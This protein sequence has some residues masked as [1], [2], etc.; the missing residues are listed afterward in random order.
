MKSSQYQYKTGINF[1]KKVAIA[2]P[3]GIKISSYQTNTGID[4]QIFN[5]PVGTIVNV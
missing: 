5:I 4:Y 3:A 1:K 2:V